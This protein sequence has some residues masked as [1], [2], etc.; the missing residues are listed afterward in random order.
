[1]NLDRE[2]G[3]ALD[4]L[5]DCDDVT[6]VARIIDVAELFEQTDDHSAASDRIVAQ[7]YR[8]IADADLAATG[9]LFRRFIRDSALEPVIGHVLDVMAA[10]PDLTRRAALV[11]EIPPLL[12]DD[13]AAESIACMP[14]GGLVGGRDDMYWPA[15]FPK[16]VR[17]AVRRWRETRAA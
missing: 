7:I 6:R 15:S 10:E 17:N 14:Y 8:L 4:A 9:Q 2:I 3:R 12:D 11:A 13:T 16:L 5:A 1:M